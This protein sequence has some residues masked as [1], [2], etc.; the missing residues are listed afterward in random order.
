M[1][2]F[3][4]VSKVDMGELKNA[5][6]QTQKEIATRFDFKGSKTSVELTSEN[7]EIMA[8]DESKMKSAL[9]VL[10]TKM[11]KRNVGMRTLEAGPVEPSSGQMWKQ[12]LKLKQ[13]VDKDQ[14]RLL[15]RLVKESGLKV[16]SSYMDEKVRVQSKKIDDLQSL[17][18]FVKNHKE[19]LIDLQ[20][21]NMKRD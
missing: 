8:E 3:D 13:G 19:V 21:E 7:V 16:T 1:P 11:A 6:L 15:N 14:G 9:D 17:W 5:I 20:M 4:I 2:S 10:R 12:V 18:A